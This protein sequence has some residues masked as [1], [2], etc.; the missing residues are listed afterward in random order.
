LDA[1]PTD[2][3]DQ[4][5]TPKKI[6]PRSVSQLKLYRQCSLS[7]KF[8]KFD[9]IK[10]QPAAWLP[11]G[12]AFGY[13]AEMWERTGRTTDLE[14]QNMVYFDKF[15]SEMDAYKEVQPD[16]SKWLTIGRTRIE[17]D[18]TARRQRGWDQWEVYRDRALRE[19]WRP[20]EMPDGT[21][22]VEV[23]FFVDLGFGPIRGKIDLV[24]E[25]PDGDVTV[26]DLKTGN[27]EK[28]P[29]QL[30]VYAVALNE[31][32]GLEVTKGSFYYAKDD[33]YSALIDLSNLDEEYLGGEFQAMERGIEAR[34]FNANVG[35]HC[36]LC[37]AKN[38]CTEYNA[39]K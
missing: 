3:P 9:K 30:A 20:W 25:W 6:Y 22:A 18:I 29:L 4:P 5:I 36:V 23:D 27:R 32:F 31:M 26:N 2:E 14:W 17:N 33:T 39:M 38:Q 19:A 12:T 7:W 21:P 24:K 28:T 10:N 34:V 13:V 15:D 16:L 11:Q 37:P 8:Q 1:T 35:D